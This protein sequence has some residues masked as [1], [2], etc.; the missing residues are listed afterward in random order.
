MLMRYMRP[1]LYCLVFLL[2]AWYLVI[3]YWVVNPAVGREYRLYYIERSLTDWPGYGGLD[4]QLGQRLYFGSAVEEG[5]RV[6]HRGRG[7]V[8]DRLEH[9]SWT[10]GNYSELLFFLDNIASVDE[11]KLS[12]LASSWKVQKVDVSING[13]I[14]EMV[15][16]DPTEYREYE[17]LLKLEDPEPDG[18]V[19][20]GFHNRDADDSGVGEGSDDGV[21]FVWVELSK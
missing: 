18:L 2:G 17:V 4:Y 3:A 7:W 11:L 6:K 20:I 12:F 19:V 15:V 14:A 16:I 8:F 21:F 9:G 13:N 5:R 1:F 10:V